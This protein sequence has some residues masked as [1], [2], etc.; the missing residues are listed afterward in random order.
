MPE[1]KKEIK[2]LGYAN[3]WGKTPEIVE[4]CSGKKHVVKSEKAGRCQTKY[5][6]IECGYTYKI[7]SSG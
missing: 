7:D 4:K 1:Q 6:C 2:N 5:T 3:G